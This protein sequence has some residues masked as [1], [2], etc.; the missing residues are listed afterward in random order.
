MALPGGLNQRTHTQLSAYTHATLQGTFHFWLEAVVTWN[1]DIIGGV[2]PYNVC[3]VQWTCSAAVDLW[4]CRATLGGTP[5]PGVG[6]LVGSGNAVSANV[7]TSFNV[8][9]TQLT[10]GDG[11]YQITVYVQLGGIWY[12]G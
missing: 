4:E 9:N 1:R 3:N 11:V 10:L 5:A 7:N 12:G 8:T 6:L 2:S